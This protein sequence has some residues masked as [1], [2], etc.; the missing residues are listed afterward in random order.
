MLRRI[1]TRA[2]QDLPCPRSSLSAVTQPINHHVLFY[3]KGPQQERACECA[4]VSDFVSS[5]VR[6]SRKL[7][8]ENLTIRLNTATVAALLVMA[9]PTDSRKPIPQ[10]PPYGD[11]AIEVEQLNF[12]YRSDN[13]SFY[14]P[15]KDNVVLQ[16]LNLNLRKGSRCLLIG[17][18]GSG[19]S[20]RSE[21]HKHATRRPW[22]PLQTLTNHNTT[23]TVHATDPSAHSCGP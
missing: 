14:D 5:E 19:K 13:G 1:S 16:N 12:A 4:P 18:N 23:T 2:T 22:S 8:N 20:V 11:T 17:A 9:K 10:I 21:H 3:G 6:Q 7:L 15:A